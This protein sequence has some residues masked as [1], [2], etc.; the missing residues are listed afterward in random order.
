MPLGRARGMR[1]T[2]ARARM[3]AK[4]NV[5]TGRAHFKAVGRAVRQLTRARTKVQR[6]ARKGMAALGRATRA[7]F[8]G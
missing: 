8:G 7:R 6:H 1:A 2:R 3:K 5:A 4:A